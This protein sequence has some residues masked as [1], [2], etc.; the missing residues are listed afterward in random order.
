MEPQQ[1][2]ILRFLFDKRLE[3]FN[4]RRDHEWK[5]FF[6]AMAV[7]GAV[8]GALLLNST[9]LP[10]GAR[11]GWIVIIA[12]LFFSNV[13]YQFELQ[14]RNRADRL[15]MNEIYGKMCH[16]AGFPGESLINIPVDQVHTTEGTAAPYNASV[17]VETTW[18][19]TYLW[20]FYWQSLVLLVACIVSGYLPYTIVPAAPK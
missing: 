6:G 20:A 15:V 9:V 17:L 1:L 4:V 5:V 12:S 10:A 8:D 19:Y 14:R 16:S 2:E 11:L 3:L 7:L 18:K 13:L